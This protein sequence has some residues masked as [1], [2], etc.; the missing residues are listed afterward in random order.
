VA[1]LPNVEL[2]I[3]PLDVEAP[4][5]YLPQFVIFETP[6]ETLATIETYSAELVVRDP[7]ELELYALTLER[8]RSVA[9]WGSEAVG[10]FGS[11]EAW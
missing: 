9:V 1:T 3:I 4:D 7:A 2:G 11:F 5:A 8:L 6:D 10:P